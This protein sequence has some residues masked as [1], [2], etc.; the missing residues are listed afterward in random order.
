MKIE[1]WIEANFKYLGEHIHDELYERG[2]ESSYLPI[3]WHIRN[4]CKP[5]FKDEI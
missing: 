1:E 2:V 4:Y 3:M 5:R